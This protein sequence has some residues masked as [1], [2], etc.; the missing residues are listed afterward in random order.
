[1]RRVPQKNSVQTKVTDCK[2]NGIV[3][4][5]QTCTRRLCLIRYYVFNKGGIK[6]ILLEKQTLEVWNKEIPGLKVDV[7]H[8]DS[9]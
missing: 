4:N 3:T 5:P 1:M 6:I 2:P 9:I 8:Y 7:Y